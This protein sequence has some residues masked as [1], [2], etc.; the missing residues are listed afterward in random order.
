MQSKYQKMQAQVDPDTRKQWSEEQQQIKS[1]IL[2]KDCLPDQLRFIAGVDI[3]FSKKHSDIAVSTVSLV[4][5]ENKTI[6]HMSSI[7]KINIPYVPGFLAFRE[8]NT[9]LSLICKIDEELEA[10]DK[11]NQIDLV[12]VDGNGILHPNEC[13]LASHL[14]VLCDKPTIGCAKKI[15]AI[16][17]LNRHKVDEIKQ[18]FKGLGE[19]IA[20]EYL[21][22]NSGRIW[23]VA[24]K[25]T[26]KS[27]DPLIV[28]IGNKISIDT[29]VDLTKRFSVTR[30]VQPVKLADKLSRQLINQF[31]S[32]YNKN[33]NKLSEA[34]LIS[35]FQ[36]IIDK[37]HNYLK[38]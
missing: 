29:A 26:A 8:V 5:K 18:K 10:I 16:D 15:F 35:E 1:K 28:S 34:E 21:K 31:E 32:F 19:Q 14:G 36:T 2:E 30:V 27:Y 13:G 23:G 12:F 17:G 4:N 37:K 22:G 25:N 6:G 38:L 11:E 9:I 24:L 7:E 33:K 3:S 20:S